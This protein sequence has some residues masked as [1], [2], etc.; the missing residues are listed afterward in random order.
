MMSKRIVEKYI[1][2]TQICTNCIRNTLPRDPGWS[3]FRHGS[4]VQTQTQRSGAFTALR[5]DRWLTWM[6]HVYSVSSSSLTV[7]LYSRSRF[8]TLL[9]MNRL[10]IFLSGSRLQDQNNTQ[11]Q[12]MQ[13]NVTLSAFSGS[14]EQTAATDSAA[15]ASTIV[16]PISFRSLWLRDERR[17]TRGCPH[18]DPE[19]GRR[20]CVCVR[21]LQRTQD[22]SLTIHR[23]R[24]SLVG[25]A[26]RRQTS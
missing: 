20:C 13:V 24:F 10:N 6:V 3:G 16:V 26:W 5:S 1:S 4:S 23:R 21:G 18:P 8:L 9:L 15:E 22:L 7:Q 14:P 17:R 11:H 19:A 25:G 12:S 2:L